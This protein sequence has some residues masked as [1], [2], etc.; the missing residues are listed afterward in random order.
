MSRPKVSVVIPLFNKADY[1][2]NTLNSVASQSFHDWECI[3]IDDGS[4]DGSPEIVKAF[5]GAHPGRWSFF[6]QSNSGPSSARNLGISYAKGEYIAFLDADDFWHGSK[7]EHQVKFMDENPTLVMTLTQ[8]LIFS[9]KGRLSIKVV[10]FPN[11]EKLLL[12][13]LRMTG[14]GGL[15]ESTGMIRATL[16]S[17][18]SLFDT[19]LKTS[20]GLDFV[21]RWKELGNVD[22]VKKIYCFYRISPNQ[23]HKDESLVIESMDLL[24]HRYARGQQREDL[25]LLHSSYF[26]LSSFRNFGFFMKLRQLF[27]KF[28]RPDVPFLRV[29]GCILSRNF[30]ARVM[31]IGKRKYFLRVFKNVG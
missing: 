30:K 2:L 13:W 24:T 26:E 19:N 3:I 12:G 10:A 22:L 29:F 15:V 20:E 11:I 7:L 5:V 23:L 25:E 17:S 9:N 4:T 14:F 16:V 18:S 8:Y 1:V 6:S 28:I 21:L 27:K 31:A